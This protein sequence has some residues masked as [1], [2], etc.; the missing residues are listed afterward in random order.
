MLCPTQ[1]LCTVNGEVFES[2]Q[3]AARALGHCESDEHYHAALQDILAISS[4][5]RARRF[6]VT[7]FVCCDV[8]SPLDLWTSFRDDL[9][10]DFARELPPD[11]AAQEVLRDMQMHCAAHGRSLDAFDL[12]LPDDFDLE[13]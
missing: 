5:A 8:T 13:A 11:M 7:M 1:A 2:F 6:L 9:C 12:P 4:A 10:E 3:Q